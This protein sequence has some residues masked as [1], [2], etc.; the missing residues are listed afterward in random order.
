MLKTIG[1]RRNWE[2]FAQ[3]YARGK[4]GSTFLFVGPSGIG[5]RTFAFDLAKSLLCTDKP[6]NRLD[7]CGVCES[8][9]LFDHGTHPDFEYVHRL[10]GK[11]ELLIHQFI[12]DEDNR[13]KEGL[14]TK[15]CLTPMIGN[16]KVGVID[17]ADFFRTEAANSMLKVLEEPPTDSILIIIGTNE[18]R[19][20]PTIRSRSQIIHFFPLS[21][22]EVKS[23]LDSIELDDEFPVSKEQ[24]SENATD[25][26]HAVKAFNSDGILE[27]RNRLLEQLATLDPNRNAFAKEVDA[28]ITELGEIAA[29]KYGGT[30]PGEKRQ[31]LV[32][33]ANFAIEF[34]GQVARL[35]VGTDFDGPSAIKPYIDEAVNRWHA[36]PEAAANC[37]DR[38][39]DVPLQIATNANLS[40]VIECWLSDLARL[41]H[42]ESEY[43]A[44][45]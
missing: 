29:D 13:N 3:A 18:Q 4:L 42:G 20:L 7:A 25:N 12:G 35:L 11:A 43:N 34:Y 14:R 32:L 8:C 30:V 6:D 45:T 15:L 39:Q 23:V 44:I 41:A 21:T 17:D 1:H 33:L 24:L 28:F 9:R 16:C 38:C 19:I 36:G 2:R 5:K 22:D 26:L 31:Y 37:L 27:F 40:T 10:P